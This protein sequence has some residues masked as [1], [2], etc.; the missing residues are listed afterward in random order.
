MN[1]YHSHGG[2]EAH[3][4]GPPQVH[5]VSHTKLLL[6]SVDVYNATRESGTLPLK[7]QIYIGMIEVGNINEWVPWY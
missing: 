1:I 3:L 7:K 2:S 6:A 4:I 5:Y